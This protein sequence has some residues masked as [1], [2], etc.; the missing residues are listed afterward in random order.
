MACTK[1]KGTEVCSWDTLTVTAV[2]VDIFP[3]ASARAP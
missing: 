2:N 1:A 3:A